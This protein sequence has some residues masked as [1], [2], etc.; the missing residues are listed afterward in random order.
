VIVRA[1]SVVWNDGSLGCPEPG[2]MYTEA[3]VNGYWVI[4]RARGQTYDFR[5]DSRGSFVSAEHRAVQ[6]RAVSS[7]INLFQRKTEN[8]RLTLFRR[9]SQSQYRSIIR[10]ASAL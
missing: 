6:A 5:A 2:N 8:R 4:I 9:F 1:E 3:L 7:G 10:A